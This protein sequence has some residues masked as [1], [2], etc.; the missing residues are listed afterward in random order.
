MIK[1]DQRGQV[2][3]EIILL[4][5]IIFVVVLVIA[6]H[7]GQESEANTISIAAKEGA[8]Q[9]LSNQS[10]LNR[11][12]APITVQSINM[13][14]NKDITIQIKLS[15]SLSDQNEYILSNVYDYI[16]AQGYTRDI[17][18]TNNK[19]SDDKIITGSHTYTIVII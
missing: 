6:S 7:V 14:G 5:G 16:Q 17:G 8:L 13:T 10:I 19:S 4:V 2:S 12:I 15:K 9:A 18:G 3:A 11:N 1:K